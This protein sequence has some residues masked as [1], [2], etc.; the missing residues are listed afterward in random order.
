MSHPFRPP[1]L[2]KRPLL[3]TETT[4]THPPP[5]RTLTLAPRLAR[6]R[7]D[8]VS[9][10][11]PS[12]RRSHRHPPPLPLVPSGSRRSI[13]RR[14]P[15][16]PPPPTVHRSRHSPSSVKFFFRVKNPES[17]H[18]AS[19]KRSLKNQDFLAHSL[20]TWVE[21]DAQDSRYLLV[22]CVSGD[23]AILTN[24]LQRLKFTTSKRPPQVETRKKRETSLPY[25]EDNVRST[26]RRSSR[27]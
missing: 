2:P 21:R 19:W 23:E 8:P 4:S 24:H 25:Q 3:A 15:G 26:H 12:D 17:L 6:K 18:P 10:V 1:P 22:E 9:S 5:R 7:P 11:A 20:V 13:S 27:Y 14:I 16:T